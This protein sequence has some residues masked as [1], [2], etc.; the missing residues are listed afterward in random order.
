VYASEEFDVLIFRIDSRSR[1]VFPCPPDGFSLILA[2]ERS[3]FV[4]SIDR[5]TPLDSV[6]HCF[7]TLF[8]LVTDRIR[9]EEYGILL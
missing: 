6:A 3:V 2:T 9:K 7:S 8:F 5:P 4:A 1:G